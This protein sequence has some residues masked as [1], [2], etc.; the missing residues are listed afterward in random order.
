MQTLEELNEEFFKNVDQIAT[1]LL[2]GFGLKHSGDVDGFARSV[3][4]VDGFSTADN[5]P[6]PAPDLCF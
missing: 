6:P 3:A 2:V 1:E 4:S 5:R